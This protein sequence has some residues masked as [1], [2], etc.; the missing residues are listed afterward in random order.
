M[1]H[2]SIQHVYRKD[3]EEAD[4]LANQGIDQQI[5]AGLPLFN[6]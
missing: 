1:N 3:N 6:S 5:K 2:F 4:Q